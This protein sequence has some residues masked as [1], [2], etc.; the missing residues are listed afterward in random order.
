MTPDI[1]VETVTLEHG[2]IDYTEQG[3]GPPVVCVHG[4]AMGREL[5]GETATQLAK[6]GF[7]VIT[8]T[9]PLGA[10]RHPLNAGVDPSPV[11]QARIIA[12]FLDALSLDD[13]TLMGNDSGGA[14]CQLVV[15]DHS[16]R[17]G[18]LVLTNC[19]AF[20]NSPPLA[21]RW[22]VTAAR[23]KVAWRAIL[24]SMRLA[25]VRRSPIAYGALSHGDVDQWAREWVKPVIADRAIAEDTRRFVMGMRKEVTMAVADRLPSFDRPVLL[26]WGTDDRF[27][28]LRYATRLNEVFSDSRLETIDN[29]RAFVMVDQ[30]QR[31]ASLVASFARAPVETT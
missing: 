22:M 15:A 17:V 30:P 7:R 23:S 25:V 18:R 5:W 31:L 8:P 3:D 21:F 29:S 4:F 20:E 28:P 14:L 1:P 2:T 16:H 26:A 10:H 24:T 12:A 6:E 27:F 19:D 11:G 13:V 9:W